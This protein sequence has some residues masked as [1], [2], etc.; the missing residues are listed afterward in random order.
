M[1]L[2]K[3][4]RARRDDLL[5]T[6]LDDEVVVYD[7]E[8]K[9]A[10]SLNRVAVAVWHHSDGTQTIEDLQR[11]ASDEIGTPVPPEAVWLALRKLERAHLLLDKVGGSPLTRREMLGKSARYGAMAMATPLIASALV[12]VAAAAVSPACTGQVCFEFTGGCNSRADCF[13]W[14]R[15]DLGGLCTPDFFCND[16]DH[17]T[18]GPGNSCPGGSV[19]VINTCCGEGKCVPLSLEC[20]PGVVSQPLTVSVGQT[21]AAGRRG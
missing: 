5:T 4:P 9:Q 16:P 18:C 15:F 19:C 20:V 13:C 1:H 12:P 6:N 14:T 11:L 7:P 17:P 2:P 21:S 10:H 8:R 3:L